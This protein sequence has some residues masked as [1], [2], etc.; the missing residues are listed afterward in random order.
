LVK[1][2]ADNL[3]MAVQLAANALR[4]GWYTGVGWLASQGAS[5][6]QPSR[7]GHPRRPVPPR[8]EV[9]A[10]LRALML[11]DARAVRDGLLP[12]EEPPTLSGLADH[13]ARLRAMMADLPATAARR[14]N[15]EAGTAAAMPGADSVPDYY[16]Q[17][18][19]F[20]TGGYLSEASARLY[21]IQVE[22][23][24][25]GA[26][27]P[28]R[29]AALVPVARAIEG[30]DQRR[31]SLLDVAC[32][33]GRLLRNIR[34]AF[35][36]LHLTGLDLSGPYLAEAARQLKG[37]RPARLVAANAEAMPLADASQDIVTSIFLFHEL[38]ADARRRV[39]AEMARVLK[40]GGTLVIADSLQLGD[41]PEWDG[42]LEAFPARFH[43]P[44]YRHYLT[45]DLDG[46]LR[47][48]G[49]LHVEQHVSY[50]SKIFVRRKIG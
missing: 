49:L 41:K 32:G 40:P 14:R 18:F 34:L 31:L 35:P 19:H 44:Y 37:L 16:R 10:A 27:E 48:A 22:T 17:D 1:D 33:T 15:G 4:L 24:F 50:L 26:A 38:P 2:G 28:M 47:D 7:A 29:R 30:R 6:E 8:A 9:M 11:A 12:P 46:V 43:E 45:D 21:D 13:A 23:L 42:M 5:R 20:Q 25:K 39:I 3:A 36:A